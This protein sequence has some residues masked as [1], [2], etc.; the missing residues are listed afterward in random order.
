M[1]VLTIALVELYRDLIV[2]ATLEFQPLLDIVV[3]GERRSGIL[4]ATITRRR[5]K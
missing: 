2:A 3:R 4:I 5:T 1:L